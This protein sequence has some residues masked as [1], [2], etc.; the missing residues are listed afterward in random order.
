MAIGFPTK[1]NWAAG[2]VL[3]ASAQDDLAGTLNLLN[4]TAKGNLISASAANTPALLTVG[5]DGTTLVA[6]SASATGMAWAGPTFAAGKNKIINGD[7]GIWQR[8]TSFN[9][10]TLFYTADRWQGYSYSG[11]SQTIT[12]QAF[13]AGTAP[14]AG[15]EAQYFLR[16]TATNTGINIEQRIEDVRTY[17]GQTVTL[18]FWAKSNSAQTITIYIN[19]NFGSGGSTQVTGTSGTQALTTSWTR[20]T[21]TGT[22]PSIAGKTIGSSSYLQVN[23]VGATIN[24]AMDIWGAQLEAGSVATP[25]TTAT[26]TLQGELAACQR[27]YYRMTGPLAFSNFGAGYGTSATNAFF[28][29][30]APVTMRTAA[31]PSVDFSNLGGYDG[32]SISA[33]NSLSF[34]ANQSSNNIMALTGVATSGFVNLRPVFLLANNNAAAYVGISQEL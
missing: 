31:S 22:L 1:A 24:N 30:I 14:I 11:A 4:P 28:Q 20:F 12:Q 26:G 15:Y 34:T 27:Y 13:T 21:L 18:S 23:F 29:V 25:F 32:I 8:G 6:N 9:S 3:T 10:S 33:L 17:A 5:S 16:T 7:F 19:Q 2:D